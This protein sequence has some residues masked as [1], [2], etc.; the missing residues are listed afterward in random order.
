MPHRG[1]SRTTRRQ[2]ELSLAVAAMFLSGGIFAGLAASVFPPE[3][4]PPLWV[5]IFVSGTALLVTLLVL[6]RGSRLRLGSAA[7]TSA[8]YLVILLFLIATSTSLG[9]ST[10]AA[11]LTV[12][13]IVLYA[14]FLPT[15]YAR[16]VGYTCLVLFAT[17]MVVRYR[18][19]DA[20]LT[21]VALVGL[22]I[23]LTEVF[24]RFKLNLEQ[25]SLTDHLCE[26]WNRRGFDVLLEKE[27]LTV[28]RTRE[29]LAMVFLDLDGFKGINDSRGHHEGDIVLQEVSRAL[30]EGVRSGDCVAR[31]GGDEFVLL[32]PRTNTIEAQLLVDRLRGQVTACGW[33]AGIAEYQPGESSYEFIKRAD[34]EMME[35]KR[36]RGGQHD[37]VS[38]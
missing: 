22:S 2:S 24:G 12:V 17:I 19:N 33:S 29:P 20:Y 30:V 23:L 31:V 26:V 13:V 18:S 25:S 34:N 36:S 8:I 21:A 14:W 37:P 16:L 35:Q 9:R 7:L 10:V 27:I 4:R 6:W 5:P 1:R 15:K 38:R 28:A 3:N 32:L 11:M